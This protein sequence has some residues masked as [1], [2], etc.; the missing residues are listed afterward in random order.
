MA[1]THTRQHDTHATHGSDMG[2]AFAG[3]VIGAVALLLLLGATGQPEQGQ[4][5]GFHQLVLQPLA[6]APFLVQDQLQ[7]QRI[8]TPFQKGRKQLVFGGKASRHPGGAPGPHALPRLWPCGSGD[9]P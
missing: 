1:D 6:A 9:I 2:A 8:G 4:R 3:L 7:R 5:L